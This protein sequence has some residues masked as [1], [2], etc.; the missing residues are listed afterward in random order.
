MSQHISGD[1]N[2]VYI[3]ACSQERDEQ[4]AR[5]AAGI[6]RRLA[7]F[8]DLLLKVCDFRPSRIVFCPIASHFS[9]MPGLN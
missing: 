3:Q 5:A 8:L 7:V 6:Q 2:T 1:I 9:V 4:A